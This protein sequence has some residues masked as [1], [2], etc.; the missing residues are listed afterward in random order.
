MGRAVAQ[1]V[2]HRL[3]TAAARVRSQ[4]VIFLPVRIPENNLYIPANL[5]E[6]K[7]HTSVGELYVSNLRL[8]ASMRISTNMFLEK[9]KRYMRQV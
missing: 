9:K 4:A 7:S 6:V 1:V 3:P 8:E 5:S 2:S